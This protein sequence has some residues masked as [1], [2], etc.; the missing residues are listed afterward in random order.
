LGEGLTQNVAPL[1]AAFCTAEQGL[2]GNHNLSNQEVEQQ[3]WS[4]TEQGTCNEEF[5]FKFVGPAVKQ[6]LER[7]VA[8]RQTHKL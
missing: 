2:T 1:Q 5:C 7:L 8:R 4:F 6:V 3:K